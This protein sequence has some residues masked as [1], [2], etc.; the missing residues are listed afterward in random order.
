MSGFL[1]AFFRAYFGMGRAVNFVADVAPCA[2]RNC[3]T[4]YG[5]G[6]VMFN[7]RLQPCA[8]ASRR[9]MQK[10][11]AAVEATPSGDVFWKLGKEPHGQPALQ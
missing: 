10:H 1:Q 4:C 3:T 7:F 8:C 9:F 6:T 11:G 5:R 2:R